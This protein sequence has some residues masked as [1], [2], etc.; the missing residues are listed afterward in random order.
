MQQTNYVHARPA[1]DYKQLVGYIKQ[2]QVTLLRQA[3]KDK[4]RE[5]IVK[6]LQEYGTKP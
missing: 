5:D 1:P 3:L 2:G 4:T 6:L